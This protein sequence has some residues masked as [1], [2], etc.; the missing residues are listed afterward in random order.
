MSRPRRYN[1]PPP[2]D[3]ESI[4]GDGVIELYPTDDRSQNPPLEP[5]QFL[6]SGEATGNGIIILTSAEDHG[7]YSIW[8]D[9]QRSVS[10]GAR[11]R[12]EQTKAL[13]VAKPGCGPHAAVVID[14]WA[15]R[16]WKSADEFV[17]AVAAATQLPAKKAERETRKVLREYYLLTGDLD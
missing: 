2:D 5:V 3:A 7:P 9:F 13:A 11:A 14:L 10:P 4:T 16:A 6:P 8:Y 17:T 15:D 1:L 12:H